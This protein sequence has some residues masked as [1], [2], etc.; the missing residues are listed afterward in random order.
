MSQIPGRNTDYSDVGISAE[1]AKLIAEQVEDEELD[2]A[3]QA[4]DDALKRSAE[5]EC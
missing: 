4:L 5:A 2:L 3:A 1:L